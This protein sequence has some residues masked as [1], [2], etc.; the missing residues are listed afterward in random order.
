MTS[1]DDESRRNIKRYIL[2]N[3][4]LTICLAVSQIFIQP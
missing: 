3:V 1:S 2:L 4:F